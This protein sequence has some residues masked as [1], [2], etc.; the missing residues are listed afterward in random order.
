[1]TLTI[2]LRTVY[3]D[4]THPDVLKISQSPVANPSKM[5]E[6]MFIRSHGE[7][8]SKQKFYLSSEDMIQFED[9]IISYNRGFIDLAPAQ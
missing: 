3:N 7:N 5:H 8:T 6:I 9:T 2:T 1:M 4:K